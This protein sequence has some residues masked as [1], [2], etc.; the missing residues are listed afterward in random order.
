MTGWFK[1]YFET[2]GRRWIL[3]LGALL[4]SALLSVFLGLAALYQAPE[5]SVAGSPS[6]TKDIS[7]W[8]KSVA[9]N[10]F[11]KAIDQ[12]EL[13]N[14]DKNEEKSGKV[15]NKKCLTCKI[16]TNNKSDIKIN[17]FFHVISI[18]YCY[19]HFLFYFQNQH[20]A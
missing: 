5:R 8:I 14:K 16:V 1:F 4:L 6:F 20:C 7:E 17:A 9:P 12:L 10:S 2:L 19:L 11:G 13:S 18:F 3:T 15:T